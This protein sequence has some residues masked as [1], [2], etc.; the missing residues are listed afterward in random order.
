MSA[1][2][3]TL[4]PRDPTDSGLGIDQVADLLESSGRTIV[5]ELRAA[6]DI[7]TW[8]PADGEW[9]ATEVV[10]HLIEADRRGFAGR[11][12]RILETDGVAESGWDQ[13]AV[14]IERG[15]ARRSGAELA[16]EFQAVRADSVA[17]VRSLRPSDLGRT[18]VHAAAGPV[19]IRDLLQ[20][21]VFH[22][23]NHL[24]QLLANVQARVWPAMGNTRRFTDPEA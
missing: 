7:A 9:T 23:R 5:S 2:D 17:L 13:R 14:A 1:F 12:R 8:Q 19:A 18:A 11:I 4:A 16:D 3:P 24:R 20:E 15:D 6:A 10:G 21:W 22:D